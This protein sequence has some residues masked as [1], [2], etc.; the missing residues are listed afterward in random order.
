MNLQL[1]TEGIIKVVAN[2]VG[3]KYVIFNST[4]IYTELFMHK[5][6]H[7]K[8]HKFMQLSTMLKDGH[9]C[10]DLSAVTPCKVLIETAGC[11]KDSS[12]F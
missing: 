11:G 12:V 9:N 10:E 3:K 8:D 1:K 4:F 7:A 6:Q 2:I 5:M